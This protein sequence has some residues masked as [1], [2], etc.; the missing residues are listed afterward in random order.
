MLLYK[1]STQEE[2]I[3]SELYYND[4][5]FSIEFNDKTPTFFFKELTNWLSGEFDLYFQEQE[6]GIFKIYFPNGLISVSY[7]NNGELRIISKNKMKLQCK[8]NIIEVLR[9]YNRFKII[10]L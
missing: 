4:I 6:N 9:S 2:N 10:K 3:L 7:K 1:L 8:K 5:Y